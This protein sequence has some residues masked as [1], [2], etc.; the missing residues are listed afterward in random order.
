MGW[1]FGF[2]L[3][4]RLMQ[5][6]PADAFVKDGALGVVLVIARNYQGSQRV[7]V[8]CAD[9]AHVRNRHGHQP[10]YIV[11]LGQLFL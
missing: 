5:V 8:D 11:S 1:L 4:Q 7:D 3:E 6:S 9:E 2:I 10:C